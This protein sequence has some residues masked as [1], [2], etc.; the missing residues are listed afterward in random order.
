[1]I[2]YK[3]GIIWGLIFTISSLALLLAGVFYWKNLRG[4]G[5]AIRPPVGDIAGE[6]E[7][8]PGPAMND[9][10]FPLNLP[11]G[12]SISIFAKDCL[13]VLGFS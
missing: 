6:L 1:M 9:T 7:R 8:T 4:V 10:D 3:K 2:I 12:F 11:D 5:P 13:K